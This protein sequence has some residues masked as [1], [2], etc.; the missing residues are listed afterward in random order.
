M[1][2]RWGGMRVTSCSINHMLMGNAIGRGWS[3]RSNEMVR[4][5]IIVGEIR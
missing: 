4:F 5:V 3:D 1:P 2:R